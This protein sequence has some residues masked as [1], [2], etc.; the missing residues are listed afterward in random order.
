MENCKDFLEFQVR[1]NTARLARN[2]LVLLEDIQ[3][4]QK[5]SRDKLLEILPKEY[6]DY[7]KLSTMITDEDMKQLRKRILDGTNDQLR[8]I[9]SDL[10]NYDI[11]F[12]FRKE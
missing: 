3:V 9:L 2:L 12:K 5:T 4:R 6:H 7:I 8:D 11:D 10:K 1:R